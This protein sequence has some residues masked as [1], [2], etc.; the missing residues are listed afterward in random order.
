MYKA[1]QHNPGAVWFYPS[2]TSCLVLLPYP[3][4]GILPSPS[5]SL[6]LAISVYWQICHHWRWSWWSWWSC[7]SHSS[8][9]C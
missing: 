1:K 7:F 6:Y 4:L 2:M 8:C 3:P 5:L 9:S